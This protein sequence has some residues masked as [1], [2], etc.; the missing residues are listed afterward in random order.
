MTVT[1][2]TPRTQRLCRFARTR[3]TVVGVTACEAMC[4]NTGYTVIRSRDGKELA[5]L[6]SEHAHDLSAELSR[7]EHD[8]ARDWKA[9]N[10]WR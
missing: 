9:R 10:S 2:T 4:H 8:V 1:A 3:Y 7:A 5:S 6:C